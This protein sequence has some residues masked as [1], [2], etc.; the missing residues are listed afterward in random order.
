MVVVQ[1]GSMRGVRICGSPK[2]TG[3]IPSGEATY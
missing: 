3:G 1:T 2:L